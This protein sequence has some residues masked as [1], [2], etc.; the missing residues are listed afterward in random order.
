MKKSIII[1]ISVILI[2]ALLGVG[3]YFGYKHFF[4]GNGSNDPTEPTV[5]ATVAPATPDQP[6]TEPVKLYKIGIVQNGLGNASKACYEGFITELNERG[7]LSSV[8]IV[9]I[10]EDDKEKCAQKIQ[11]LVDGDVDLLYTIGR[12]ATVT[13]A[14]KTKDIPIVFGAVNSPDEIGLVES[15]EAPGGNVTGVSSFTPCFEQIDLIQLLLPDAK[16]LA[17]IYSATDA[18][19]V[20]Q[21]I[22]A[23]SEGET[24]GLTCTQYP[25]ENE[26]KLKTTLET[27]KESKT[28]VIYVPVD[29]FL[30]KHFDVIQKFSEENKIPI[31]CGDEAT[32]S[33]GAFATSEVNYSSIGR[34]AAGMSIDILFSGKSPATLSVVYKHDCINIVN[35]EVADKLGKKIP[36]TAQ[37]Q[38]KYLEKPTET[39]IPTETMASP[40]LSSN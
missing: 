9:Y 24:I 35:K 28:D 13:S 33:S 26:K 19:A 4:A 39:P 12:Y 32:L 31:I 17:I 22:I 14:E 34:K 10:V 21:G 37:N 15:N 1:T 7:V 8:E 2:V 40:T 5:D 25:I 29:K 38:V 23:A 16:N 30:N 27:I 36:A 20:S 6:A 18:D 11:Q 3:G